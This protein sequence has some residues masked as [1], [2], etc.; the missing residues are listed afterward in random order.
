MK[1]PVTGPTAGVLAGLTLAGAALTSCH[2]A[3]AAAQQPQACRSSVL[4]AA[5]A[6][7]LSP[8]TG[9]HGS[10][11]KITNNGWSGCTLTGYPEVTLAVGKQ[12]LPFRY[13]HG[14]GA[15]VT[16]ARPV[17][18]T[19]PPGGSA[20]VLVAKYRCDRGDARRAGTI[21]L[22]FGGATAS[23]WVS[24]VPVPVADLSYCRGGAG[25]PGNSI[26]VSPVEPSQVACRP[27]RGPAGAGSMSLGKESGRA[28]GPRARSGKPYGVT[29]RGRE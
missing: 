1:L 16:G 20:W 2:A 25:D 5:R 22:A 6:P 29:R 7:G 13:R 10:F 14:G 15:Y 23:T 4:G 28:A 11:Y 21:R 17:K 26:T 18:V 12:V 27:D 24:E 3:S 9:E 19:L 8:M